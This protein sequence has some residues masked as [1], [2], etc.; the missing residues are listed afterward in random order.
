MSSVDLSTIGRGLTREERETIIR[1]S[2]A[3]D[4][5]D[6][7]TSDPVMARRLKKLCASL[8]ISLVNV[9]AWGVRATLPRSCVRLHKPMAISDEERQR[10]ADAL[11]ARLA[12]REQVA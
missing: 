12:Q 2:A 10:R 1:T 6:V 8:G 4:T 7:Y 9:D 5:W 11:R 3:D